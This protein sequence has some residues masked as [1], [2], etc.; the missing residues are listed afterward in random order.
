[1]TSLIPGPAWA[2]TIGSGV[3]RCEGIREGLHKTV[4][5]ALDTSAQMLLKLMTSTRDSLEQL[6]NWLIPATH[7]HRDGVH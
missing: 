6:V 7:C 2:T 3:P 4:C 5:V 1:M